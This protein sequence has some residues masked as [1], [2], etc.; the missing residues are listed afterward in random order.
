MVEGHGIV[1]H[2]QLL[3]GAKGADAMVATKGWD[4]MRFTETQYLLWFDVACTV[5]FACLASFP[6]LTGT[7]NIK[8]MEPVRNNLLVWKH[9]N[10][11]HVWPKRKRMHGICLQ[12]MAHV[13]VSGLQ[14]R[15]N[16]VPVALRP[17]ITAS[18][19]SIGELPDVG[20]TWSEAI[21]QIVTS[22]FGELLGGLLE[23]ILFD[24]DITWY[25]YH[26]KSYL[27]RGLSV[28]ATLFF[29]TNWAYVMALMMHT[30]FGASVLWRLFCSPLFLPVG[31]WVPFPGSSS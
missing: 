25:W 30:H 28:L 12:Q 19:G 9:E 13:V 5:L 26:I 23:V 1:Q 21:G 27:L 16:C 31:Q 6:R 2:P 29:L 3:Y 14:Y 22:L 24:I 17:H 15:N 8:S 7:D 11:I 18:I 20:S 10:C 4:L